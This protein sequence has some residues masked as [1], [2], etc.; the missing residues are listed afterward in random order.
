MKQ[1]LLILFLFV[2]HFSQAQQPIALNQISI[3]GS[4]NINHFELLFPKEQ[5][6][7]SEDQANSKECQK[8]N[9]K[10]PVN[11]FIAM[12]RLF[13]ANFCKLVKAK[14]YP[15]IE[16]QVPFSYINYL[17]ENSKME[18]MEAMVSMAGIEKNARVLIASNSENSTLLNGEIKL[19][20]SD[21]DLKPPKKLFGIIKVHN[22][23]IIN[24]NIDLKNI[25]H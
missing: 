2:V 20:L 13:Y 23:V 25:S 4:S 21:F 5:T 8:Y 14:Q 18:E 12:N 10:I 6:I 7:N 16:V 19:N 11:D 24:F 1:Q 9:F 17:K 3:K 22:E 15:Y